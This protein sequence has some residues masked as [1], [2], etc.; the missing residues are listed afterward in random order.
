MHLVE[1]AW[2]GLL[3][4]GKKQ[5]GK[6]SRIIIGGPRTDALA[7]GNIWRGPCS[8]IFTLRQCFL[9]ADPGPQCNLEIIRVVIQPRYILSPNQPG[10]DFLRLHL[11]IRCR[12]RRPT[13]KPAAHTPLKLF[14]GPCD[15]HGTFCES[16]QRTFCE[17]AAEIL[18]ALTLLVRSFACAPSV[19]FATKSS[20][21]R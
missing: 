4:R 18:A 16:G 7:W 15:R 14:R 13:K 21:P 3:R 9:A 2:K 11:A 10:R 6:C 12:R 17:G 1:A 19:L 20:P 8:H 5:E